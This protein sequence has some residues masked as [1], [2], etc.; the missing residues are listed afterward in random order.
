MPRWYS[1]KCWDCELIAGVGAFDGNVLVLVLV[2]LY[3]ALG[4][5]VEGSAE[6]DVVCQ[7]IDDMNLDI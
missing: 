4:E 1:A 7:F 6:E 3:N 2:V 5:D